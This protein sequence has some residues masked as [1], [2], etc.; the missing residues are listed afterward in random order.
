M[1]WLSVLNVIGFIITGVSLLATIHF[2]YRSLAQLRKAVKT[3]FEKDIRR[4]ISRIERNK[5]QF[6]ETV[7]PAY[8]ELFDIQDELEV[9]SKKFPEMFEIK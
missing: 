4:I 8:Q 7:P 5:E 9:I 6:K 1:D 2:Y 3:V